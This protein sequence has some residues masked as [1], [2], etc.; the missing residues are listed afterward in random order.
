M[1][2]IS[3]TLQRAAISY[4]QRE[5]FVKISIIPG[6]LAHAKECTVIRVEVRWLGFIRLFIGSCWLLIIRPLR[7]P[8][9][10][11]CRPWIVVYALAA[12]VLCHSTIEG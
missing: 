8:V 1:R 2:S 6:L 5:D 9:R 10:H 7:Q 4:H 3:E 12:R 11:R